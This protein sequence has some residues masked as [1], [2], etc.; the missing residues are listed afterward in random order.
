MK[1]AERDAILLHVVFGVTTL[2]ILSL[3]TGWGSVGM[4]L[5]WLVLIYN[6]AL[7]IIAILQKHIIWLQLWA[8]LLPLSIL[9]IFPDWFLASELGTLVFPQ[10]GAPYIGMIPVYM[11]GMWIIPLF[12][13]IFTGLQVE[14]RWN[15]PAAIWA[16]ALLSLLLFA[17]SEAVLWTVPIWVAISVATV[18]HIAVYVVLPEILLGLSAYSAYQASVG[19]SILHRLAAAFVVMLLYTGSLNF[20][21]FLI[22]RLI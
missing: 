1:N 10:T 18:G 2:I 15:R 20:F 22:E 8:F 6:L 12:I 4:R 5:L 3:P 17:G 13:I 21:F 14:S 9:M 16:V 11:A 7:P 19:R